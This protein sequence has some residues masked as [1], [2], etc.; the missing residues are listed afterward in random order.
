MELTLSL[1]TCYTLGNCGHLPSSSRS[2][3]VSPRP[4]TANILPISVN[5]FLKNKHRSHL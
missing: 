5:E 4:M 1:G 2:F 3:I